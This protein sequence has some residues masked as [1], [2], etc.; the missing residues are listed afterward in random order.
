MRI[1]AARAPADAGSL[2]QWVPRLSPHYQSPTHLKEFTDAVEL[3]IA[4]EQ[5]QVV[6]HAPPRHGK[7]EAVL[8]AISY[9]LTRNPY[10]TF[11]YT[12]YNT[13]I[14]LSKSR[15]ARDLAVDKAGIQLRRN[16]LR[17]WRTRQGG[18]C[19]ATGVG[20]GLTGYGLN[21]AFVDD[22]IKDRVEAESPRR[23]ER[24]H[25]WFREVLVTR[26]EP[27]GSIFVFQTRWH[28]DDLPGRLIKDGWKYICLSALS[29]GPD[30]EQQTLWPERWPLD[31]ILGKKKDVGSYSF[32]SLFQGQ[33]RPRGGTVFG[34]PTGYQ[35]LPRMWRAAIGI[36]LAYA[37]KTSSD[38]STLVVMFE[39]LDDMGRRMGMFYIAD[40]VRV[41]MRPPQFLEICKQYRARYPNAKWRWYASGTE[42]GAASFMMPA[43]PIQVMTPRGDKFT[44]AIPYAA[45]WNASKV[46]VPGGSVWKE[47]L[48]AQGNPYPVERADPPPEWVDKVMAEHSDFTGVDD[49]HDDIVDAAVAAFDLLSPMGDTTYHS[50]R[51]AVGKSPTRRTT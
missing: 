43:I 39:G 45:A 6:V 44:R 11:G 32:E 30:G 35:K 3:A 46:A 14:A 42:Q 47:G 48:D 22:S 19:M 40:V 23:R 25:D 31:A 37:A 4:G 18:G 27:K 1:R 8:H 5:Q 34:A 10:L 38:W 17:E 36:D 33:P 13:D 50:M 41:Q 51:D 20:G 26:V 29:E 9:G 15:V 16:S 28:P 12:S 24:I 2:Q 21:V 49:A 7:T